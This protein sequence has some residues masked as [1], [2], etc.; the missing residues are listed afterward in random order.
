M[1][2]QLP[3]FL[4]LL[5]FFFVTFSALRTWMNTKFSGLPSMLPPGPP[6]LPLIGNLH[7]LIGTQPHR[8]LARL[9][10][11][12][13]PVMFLQLGEVSTVV[14]SSPEAA[15]QVMK[16]HDSVFSERPY[17]YAAQFVTYNFRDIV[18]ARGDYM[19]QIRKI[20][21]LELLSKKRVQSFRPIREE[22][23]SNLVRTISSKAGS[24]I[25]LKNLLYSSALSILSRAA[26]GGKCKHQDAFKKLLP[27]VVALFG[28]LTVVDVYPSVKLLH[29]INAM[30]PK[31][32][33]LHNKV[34]K[35]L[36]SVI[37]EHRATKLT[38][39]TG[40]SE[41]DDLVQVLLDIQ[42]HG[43]LEVPLSTS[44][45]K[46][47]ILD[48][49]VAGGETSSTVVE[50]AMSE[51]L[52]NPEVLKRAQEEVRHVFAG[53][54]DVDELGI[55]ELKY[56]RLVI[57]ETLRLHPP[58]PLLIPRECQVN[59]EVN[60]CVIPAK[61]RVIINAWAIGQNQN[62][63]TEAEKFYPERFCDSSIT[64]KGTD[65][66]FIPFGAGRR[67][68][69]GMSYG[70][71]SVELSLANLLYHFDWKLPNGKKP[72]DLDM[73]ELFGASLQ[74]KEDLCLVPIPHHL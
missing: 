43:D 67:M 58:A 1:E 69:P 18:F 31:N 32:K 23:I 60:G 36:E 65:F 12:Y 4:F 71:A 40:E 22:E 54:R 50:W 10:Q 66:E 27:D 68:C 73:T 55:H 72:E 39:M 3:F 33:K 41:V 56:L 74:R 38:T 20:C 61:S 7:L 59:C 64:Y 30:R 47:I 25:N 5:T 13:G 2:N 42:D 53:R 35:I 19:R 15:K 37:Q 14:I 16:T 8:C 63:W 28:G 11:Q 17:L 45:I 52:R 51:L 26:F 57:K 24:P 44:S 21:V 49:F 34:D 46:A 6:K 48:M 70:I 29:L 62:Y 9:A